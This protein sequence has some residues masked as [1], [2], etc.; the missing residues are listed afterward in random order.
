MSSNLWKACF[1]A[2]VCFAIIAGPAHSSAQQFTQYFSVDCSNP[3]AQFPTISSALAAATDGTSIY[4]NPGTTCNENVTVGY[5]KNIAI[6]TDWRKTF[7]LS[8]NLTIQSSHTVEVQGMAVTS[9]SGDGIDV[10]SSTDVTLTYVSSVNNK[11]AGLLLS[12][13]QVTIAGG[14]VFSNNGNIGINAGNNSTLSILA[15]GGTVDISKNTGMGI[16]I[17]RSVMSNLGATTINNNQAASGAGFPNGFG[18]NEFG[19]AKA[20]ME[21]LF[22][23]VTISSNGAGGV[24]IQETSEISI[25]G[26]TSWAPYLIN[27]SGNGPVGIDANYGGSVTL[28]GGVTVADHTG[29][30]ISLYGNSQAAIYNSNQIV[31]NGMGSDSRRAGILVEQ[32]SEAY[33]RDATIQDNG[34]PGILGLTHATLD[35]EGSTL[36]SNADGAIVCDESTA[37]ETDL[38]RSVLGTANRCKVS[39][40]PGDYPRHGSV[41]LSLSLPDWQSMKNRSIN[42]SRMIISHRPATTP[43][44]H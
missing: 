30:G 23:P 21:A 13:S 19:G 37:L 11:G 22:G 40:T 34:G 14:G 4:V 12:T 18:I 42:L 36:S 3:S 20:L 9:P 44:G 28:F 1:S 7:T 6:V 43:S 2:L 8:G 16:N 32:G 29:V 10:N 25:G 17:D 33:V 35:V 38:T 24:S 31:H 27:I 15:W 41:D 5:L 26:N 39:S